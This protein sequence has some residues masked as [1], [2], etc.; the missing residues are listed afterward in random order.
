MQSSIDLARSG[1]VGPRNELR[2]SC[3]HRYHLRLVR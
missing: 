3:A 1:S 2:K